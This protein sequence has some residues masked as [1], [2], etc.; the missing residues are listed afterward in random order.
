MDQNAQRCVHDAQEIISVNKEG[1]L[2]NLTALSPT[3]CLSSI[4][5]R[6]VADYFGYRRPADKSHGFQST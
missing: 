2:R 1:V 3:K 5:L 6:T 4:N